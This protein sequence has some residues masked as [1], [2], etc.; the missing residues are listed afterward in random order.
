MLLLARMSFSK[1]FDVHFL[2]IPQ[3]Y[4]LGGMMDKYFAPSTGN[5]GYWTSDSPKNTDPSLA[6]IVATRHVSGVSICF[7]GSGAVT[8]M[9][10]C[11]D[12]ATI[13]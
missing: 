13:F 6:N 2:C 8:H 3:V 4:R 9:D 12:T 5:N 7:S 11:Q 1:F 10:Y